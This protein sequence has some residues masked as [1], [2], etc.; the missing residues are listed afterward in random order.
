MQYLI[1]IAC[2]IQHIDNFD[3]QITLPDTFLQLSK[4][5]FRRTLMVCKSQWSIFSKSCS[6]SEVQELRRYASLSR[7]TI[8][9]D[10]LTDWLPSVANRFM[11]CVGDEFWLIR[12]AHR[13]TLWAV[14]CTQAM[15][16]TV[17]ANGSSF[18][19]DKDKDYP[20][21]E[22]GVE[23]TGA[24]HLPRLF[25]YSIVISGCRGCPLERRMPVSGEILIIFTKRTMSHHYLC[26]VFKHEGRHITLD[27]LLQR[28]GGPTRLALPFPYFGHQRDYNVSGG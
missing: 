2:A 28:K 27:W 7:P 16:E 26:T 4:G 24:A 22:S 15:Y 18:D 19:G 17:M 11:Y 23:Q 13:L 5:L 6:N 8:I 9:R 20:G 12:L 25:S 14:V 10:L 1:W 21:T 3:D